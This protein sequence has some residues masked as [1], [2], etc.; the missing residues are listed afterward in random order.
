MMTNPNRREFCAEVG[1]GMLIA[2]VGAG[3]AA[4]LGLGTAWAGDDPKALGFGKMEPLVCLMQETAP[5]KL[6]PILVKRLRGGLDLQQLVAA[7]ALAN[8][9]T[10]G[11]EDYV[12]FHTMMALAPAFHM[13]RELPEDRRA[14]PVLKVL[15][16][17]TN[18][19]QEHGGRK[20][21]VLHA[22]R[23]AALSEGKPAGESL[24]EAVRRKDLGEAERTF[25]A[26]AQGSPEDAFNA[27][28]CAVEDNTE[29]HRVVLPYRAWDLMGLIGQEQAHTLLRQS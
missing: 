29:V 28:L 8:A 15:Y 1:R 3:L 17:N 10:F 19:I 11:G 5:D 25:A 21:E 12:G 23:P 22:V 24:R 7:A 26:V 20:S 18:R 27:L 14:L 6:L 16:R 4:D 13:S 2:S 9:R